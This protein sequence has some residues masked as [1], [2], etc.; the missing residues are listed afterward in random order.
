MKVLFDTNVLL[1]VLLSREPFREV[2]AH[3]IAKVERREVVGVLGAT[4]LTT[5][6]YLIA[7]ASGKDPAR[8]TIK[9]LLDLF[10]IAPVDH[11]VLANAAGSAIGDFEDAVLHEA[12]LSANVD[13]VVTRDPGG[14]KGGSLRILSP[15]QLQASLH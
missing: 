15:Q 13:A 10:E 12:G 3:L 4:T 8:E 14:F 11:G 7:R 9:R 2:A 5:I 1:D 6:H